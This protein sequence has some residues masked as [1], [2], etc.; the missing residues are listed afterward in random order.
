MPPILKPA[1]ID[2]KHPSIAIIEKD[3]QLKKKARISKFLICAE[4]NQESI[5]L[6]EHII[7]IKKTKNLQ[8][9]E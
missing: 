9:N 4:S 3:Y 5:E 6:I 8:K 7:K 2:N 1:K